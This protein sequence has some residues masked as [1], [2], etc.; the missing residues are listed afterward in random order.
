[1]RA[2]VVIRL[3]K[4]RHPLRLTYHYQIPP[5]S[6]LPSSLRACLVLTPLFLAAYGCAR[7][8]IYY[9]HPLATAIVDK[10]KMGE[11]RQ[12]DGGAGGGGGRPMRAGREE[13]TKEGGGEGRKRGTE[14]EAAGRR[15][16]PVGKQAGTQPEK[17]S[18]IFS[19]VMSLLPA[20]AL[21]SP[22]LSTRSAEQQVRKQTTHTRS[23]P[24]PE[25]HIHP[26]PNVMS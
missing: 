4:R 17:T 5:P 18:N 25:S 20:R 15:G 10:K 3:N 6:S 22:F 21:H 7:T 13:G 24:L 14:E 2:L 1:M 11:D 9:S 26:D 19:C 23:N 16:V 12:T 8:H